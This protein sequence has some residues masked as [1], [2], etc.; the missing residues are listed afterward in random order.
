MIRKTSI[1]L[2]GL[3]L[4]YSLSWGEPV[5]L[6]Q[7]FSVQFENVPISAV[8]NLIA[9]QYNLNIVQAMRID[10]KI[11]IRL[12]NVVLE[13]A[14]KAILLSNGYNYYFS[15]NIMVVKPL[16][17]T[18][19]GETVAQT[20]TLNYISPAAAMNSIA[21]LLSSKGKV[22]AVE[23]LGGS[24]KSGIVPRP[25]QIIVVDL[26]EAMEKITA[27]I[28]EIDKA[29]PLIGIEVKMVEINMD[30][31]KTIGINWPT[32]LSTVAGGLAVN[33][34]D[35]SSSASN[36]ALAQTE[37]SGGKWQWGRLSVQEVGAVIDF[38]N[39][40]GNSKLISDPKITTLNNHEAEIKVTT[41]YPIAT[42]NRFSDQGSVTDVVTFQDQEVGITLLVTPHIAD[43]NRILLD[44]Q[45]T[46]A[47][48][49][50]F[51]GKDQNQKPITSKRSLKTKIE[52]KSGETAVLGGLLR[53]NKIESDQSVF[54]LGSLPI[55]G[56]LFHH[57]STKT[58]TTDLVI[59]ITPIIRE[60]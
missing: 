13:D 50:G 21:D 49:V 11:S 58:S 36:K 10:D 56:N 40:S 7:R 24:T 32:S 4:L 9:E 39:T 46:V 30:K 42:I 8:L 57:K 5:D 20:F 27:F 12:D 37:L 54:L 17:K 44:V 14:L 53:E 6:S 52:V 2:I 26:P 34:N 38:L 55:I 48:I 47:E 18:A 15:G 31:E 33:S 51:T 41:I 28:K 60:N 22:K 1:T 19:M 23:D 16:D 59:F 29:E 43:G 25:S 35:T 45:P 3:L